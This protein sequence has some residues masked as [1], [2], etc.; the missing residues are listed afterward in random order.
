MKTFLFDYFLLDVGKR[1]MSEYY[2]TTEIYADNYEDAEKKLYISKGD[3]EIFSIF[4]E[5]ENL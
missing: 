4:T 3:V 2:E 1:R 5:E